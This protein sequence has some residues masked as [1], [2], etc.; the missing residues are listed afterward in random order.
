[1]AQYFFPFLPVAL[2]NVKI[3]FVLAFLAFAA[4]GMVPPLRERKSNVSSKPCRVSL[5]F[6]AIGRIKKG[7]EAIVAQKTGHLCHLQKPDEETPAE[8]GVCNFLQGSESRKYGC[9]V[10][11]WLECHHRLSLQRMP[12]ILAS[13][14]ASAGDLRRYHYTTVYPMLLSVLSKDDM[15]WALCFNQE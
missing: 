7:A 5:L 2:S 1:M 4:T 10:L 15:L 8:E 11:L 9:Q 14:F 13:R 6:V 3:S 12:K